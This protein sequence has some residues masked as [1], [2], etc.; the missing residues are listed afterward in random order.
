MNAQC[1]VM[2]CMGGID[3][4]RVPWDVW[5]GMKK[6]FGHKYMTAEELER[7]RIQYKQTLLLLEDLM[8]REYH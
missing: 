4:F 5:K 2:V 8:L 7:Y 1:Y 3:F 6:L